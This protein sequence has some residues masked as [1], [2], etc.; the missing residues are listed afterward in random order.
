MLTF[1]HTDSTITSLSG[2][3]EL[4]NK[5]I[6]LQNELNNYKYISHDKWCYVNNSF[7]SISN[8]NRTWTL[9]NCF[10][11][12]MDSANNT[13][14]MLP[15]IHLLDVNVTRRHRSLPS[16]MFSLLLEGGASPLSTTAFL[17][18]HIVIVLLALRIALAVEA[19]NKAELSHLP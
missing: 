13:I 4:S 19:G 1:R 17:V 12:A 11:N 14:V 10:H 15:H 6:M 9:H 5:F 3:H 18:S 8:S 2:G 7:I 16:A